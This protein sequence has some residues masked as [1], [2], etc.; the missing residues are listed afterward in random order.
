LPYRVSTLSFVAA[1]VVVGQAWALP[2]RQQAAPLSRI[3][4]ALE[5]R[6]DLAYFKEIEWNETGYWEIEYQDKDGRTVELKV[7]PVSGETKRR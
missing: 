1:L 7:D 2:P 4:H 5:Q 3:L 6:D